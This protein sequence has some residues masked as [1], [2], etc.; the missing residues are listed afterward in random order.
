MI[1]ERF[2]QKRMLYVAFNKAVQVEAGSSFPR[3]V[4]CRTAHALA[5][6]A[7]G[8]RM[9]KRLDAPRRTG[10]N[11]ASVLGAKSL[12][13]GDV[14]FDPGR[15]RHDD[16]GYCRP[17]LSFRR[18]GHRD[19]SF[20]GPRGPRRCLVSARGR[21]G[22]DSGAAGVA[23]PDSR[24]YG[25]P[26]AL[27]RR[28]PKAV[29]ALGPHL[30]FDVLLYDECQDAEPCVADVVERQAHAQ[31]VAVGDSA[32]AIYAWRGAGDFLAAVPTRHRLALTQSWRFGQAIADEANVWLSVIGPRSR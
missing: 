3:N 13:A 28:L 22:H 19:R 8:A 20:C 30:D 1:A 25:T 17:L 4:T 12:V 6:R 24:G 2:P 18:P 5:Y 21:G 27:A 11:N 9:A 23:G 26:K 14:V 7:F 31:L 32:Q 16:H 29:A 10:A 15:G